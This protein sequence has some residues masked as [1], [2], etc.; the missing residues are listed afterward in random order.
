MNFG[1]A[2]ALPDGDRTLPERHGQRRRD[3]RQSALLKPEQDFSG[4]VNIERKWFD[5]R[6]RLTLFDER[7]NQALISQTNLVTNPNTGVQI[8]DHHHQQRPGDPA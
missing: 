2:S 5:G 7:V 8:S 3:L 1:E 4:E 6:A